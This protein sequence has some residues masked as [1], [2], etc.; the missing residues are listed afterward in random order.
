MSRLGVSSRPDLIKQKFAGSIE[1]HRKLQRVS[2]R[3]EILLGP[4]FTELGRLY[5]F[6]MRI[7]KHR[8]MFYRRLAHS[9]SNFLQDV[10]LVK[11][12]LPD[13]ELIVLLNDNHIK[14]TPEPHKRHS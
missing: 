9:T 8:M 2:E 6:P 13:T 3:I 5:Q 14:D 12:F 7:K 1:T 4:V 10:A 11:T